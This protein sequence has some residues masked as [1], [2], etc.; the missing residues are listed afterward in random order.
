[1]QHAGLQY[2][3]GAATSHQS[4]P[5]AHADISQTNGGNTTSSLRQFRKK[6]GPEKSSTT[7]LN[8]S[9]ENSHIARVAPHSHYPA[10]PNDYYRYQHQY[11]DYNSPYKE[12]PAQVK[13]SEIAETPPQPIQHVD[14]LPAALQK[15]K[16]VHKDFMDMCNI[17]QTH[18]KQNYPD[19]LTR[20]QSYP[21]DGASVHHQYLHKEPQVHPSYKPESQ[22]QQYPQLAKYNMP[23]QC[24]KYPPPPPE[25]DFLAKLQR[26]NPSMARSIMSDHH[27]RESPAAYP[28]M[29]QNRMYPQNQRYYPPTH[30]QN[31]L[32]YNYQP[33]NYPS[34][35]NYKH[36]EYARSNQMGVGGAQYPNLNPHAE[37]SM[38]PRNIHMMNYGTSP[39]K[40]SPGYSQYNAPEYA[41]H[42]QHRRASIPQEYYQQACRANP[43]MGGHQISPESN[44]NRG[45]SGGLRHF[46]E[47]WAEEEGPADITPIFKENIRIH[48]DSTNEQVFVINSSDIPLENVALVPTENGQYIIKSDS[49]VVRIK[50]TTT[51]NNGERTVNLQIV[52]ATP[53]PDCMLAEESNKTSTEETPPTVPYQENQT[54]KDCDEETKTSQ[55]SEEQKK[56][57]EEPVQQAENTHTETDENSSSEM[58]V[59]VSNE[60][61][62]I[63]DMPIIEEDHAKNEDNAKKNDQDKKDDEATEEKAEESSETTVEEN[64]EE[65]EVAQD[66]SEETNVLEENHV[67][68]TTKRTQRI[69]SVDD[70]INNIG[71]SPNQSR[72]SS[73]QFAPKGDE[74]KCEDSP[75]DDEKLSEEA[76]EE[77]EYRSAISVD[78]D[79]VI[80]EIGGALVQLNINHLNGT[81]ILSVL[82]LTDSLVIDVNGNYQDCEESGVTAPEEERLVEEDQS[83]E[84]NPHEQIEDDISTSVC[85]SEVVIGEENVEDEVFFDLNVEPAVVEEEESPEEVETKETSTKR[86]EKSKEEVLFDLDGEESPVEVK[87]SKT[88]ATNKKRDEKSKDEVVFDLSVETVAEEKAVEVKKSKTEETNKKRDE[89][90]ERR[91]S[92]ENDERRKS[93]S[94]R[95][96]KESEERSKSKKMQRVDV[97]DSKVGKKNKSEVQKVN[98][99]KKESV[100]MDVG[101]DIQQKEVSEWKK[102]D[103]K[104]LEEENLKKK[105]MQKEEEVQ[106]IREEKKVTSQ[107]SRDDGELKKKEVIEE[108]VKS[109]KHEKKMAS[110]LTLDDEELKKKE[111]IEENVK[112]KKHEKKVTSQLTLDDEELKTKEVI[113]DNIKS[114]KHEKKATS[115]LSLDD[116]D[117]KT[118]AS[119]EE[120]VKTKKNDKKSTC[121]VSVNEDKEVIKPKKKVDQLKT[122]ELSEESVKKESDGKSG[123]E[124]PEENAKSKKSDKS[125]K[126]QTSTDRMDP[127]KESE[128]ST[129]LKKTDESKEMEKPTTK[130]AKKLY[131]NESTPPKK[132]AKEAKTKSEEK[133]KK[134]DVKRSMSKLEETVNK[135]KS[136]K[137]KSI[138]EEA[139]TK[140]GL[141]KEADKRSSKVVKKVTFNLETEV[142]EISKEEVDRR[143]LS[144][145]EYNSRKR[146]SP[147][148]GDSDDGKNKIMED[149]VTS[150]DDIN[151]EVVEQVAQSIENAILQGSS[152][153]KSPPRM[154]PSNWEDDTPSPRSPSKSDPVSGRKCVIDVNEFNIKPIESV[155]TPSPVSSSQFSYHSEDDSLQVYKDVVD[156]KLNSLNIKIPK[157]SNKPKP[158]D[159][160][161]VL[162]DRFL[163]KGTL[164]CSEL[165]KMKKIIEFKRKI[166]E[167]QLTYEVRGERD[168]KD[169]KLHFRK[170]PE[171]RKR[172]RFR[173]LY[174]EDSSEESDSS[175]SE[176]GV[177]DYSVYQRDSQ[178]VPKLIFKRKSGLPQPFVKLERSQAVEL[179]AKKR[180]LY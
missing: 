142:R 128:E 50:E 94:S 145:E 24:R 112:S 179:L 171:K 136:L 47:N 76:E 122:K 56:S 64:S 43:Y 124:M 144:W 75:V 19:N 121:Q 52:E 34:S 18:M 115:Q 8:T 61:S 155:S 45:A 25:N 130:A 83:V 30:I 78:D 38:S 174:T 60:V 81:K 138:K 166:E 31:N 11:P 103:K 95:K 175:R 137:E 173:N 69:F 102:P 160:F 159:K 62:V 97:S 117:A 7:D 21:P 1:M 131:T 113:E 37:R 116:E 42:Y 114:K 63:K 2:G 126:P 16:E 28:S 5:F 168:Y 148:Y 3:Q 59:I 123:E 54:A 70:I 14:H 150:S 106:V 46:I 163:N 65:K 135:I 20:Q 40:I 4:P 87:K 13:Y 12:T 90:N 141:V 107:V 93:S 36:P 80:L 29:D 158:V 96:S 178:G 15:H 82:P 127:V 9:I 156:S 23:S 49:S 111:V 72:R 68:T 104:D 109:K 120:S 6:D 85:Q 169:L 33:Y 17:S 57:S 91:K 161:S 100:Q 165:E 139:K 67:T 32:S 39:Q 92:K 119:Q 86:E 79:S 74:E 164:N 10:R 132:T 143:K 105:E 172:K 53:K 88:E 133:V 125:E 134:V 152:L 146:K 99:D 26:I 66:E 27:M 51:E 84:E 58:S 108:S 180:K 153:K 162:L 151:D 44:D 48:N 118:K 71:N 129:K 89:K 22:Y 77:M 167:K 110:Q 176:K 55:S 170:V 98:E 154:T 149:T 157:L 73:L 41:Q 101:E 147:Q 140:K 177:G 35:C